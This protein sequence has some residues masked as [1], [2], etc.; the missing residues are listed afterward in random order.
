MSN[1]ISFDQW[2][3]LAKAE[4]GVEPNTGVPS[5]DAIKRYLALDDAATVTL[6]N[7]LKV[8]IRKA[9]TT[10]NKLG[11]LG[12]LKASGAISSKV[13]ICLEGGIFNDQTDLLSLSDGHKEDLEKLDLAKGAKMRGAN[14]SYAQSIGDATIRELKFVFQV[15]G[16]N[17]PSLYK[18][19]RPSEEMFWQAAKAICKHVLDMESKTVAKLGPEWVQKTEWADLIVFGKK[20]VRPGCMDPN[21]VARYLRVSRASLAVGDGAN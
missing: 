13:Y 15:L 1:Q 9:S 21:L 3:K 2:V 20:L 5:I 8:A 16:L 7:K 19:N 18:E 17:N 11:Q 4:D 10:G 14:A 12:V 6:Y